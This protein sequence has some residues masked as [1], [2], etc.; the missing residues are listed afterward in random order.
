MSIENDCYILLVIL[1]DSVV[2][3]EKKI[4]STNILRRM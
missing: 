4:L 1:V 2:D 3:V